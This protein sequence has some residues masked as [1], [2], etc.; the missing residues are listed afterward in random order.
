[1]SLRI[2]HFATYEANGG[3]T[4]IAVSDGTELVALFPRIT[5]LTNHGKDEPWYKAAE[6]RNLKVRARAEAYVE[7]AHGTA[8][9]EAA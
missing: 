5:C 2:S 4:A 7:W 1:M 9:R 8:A 3:D 6:L